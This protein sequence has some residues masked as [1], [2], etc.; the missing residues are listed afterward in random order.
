M[1]LQ[2][3]GYCPLPPV[4]KAKGKDLEKHL[5]LF[6]KGGWLRASGR[7]GWLLFSS[8]RTEKTWL[9]A[10]VWRVYPGVD[11]KYLHMKIKRFDKY[12]LFC[13]SSWSCI[14][15]HLFSP[16]PP[17]P[18]NPHPIYS[19]TISL[20]SSLSCLISLPWSLLLCQVTFKLPELYEGE[21]KVIVSIANSIVFLFI[22]KILF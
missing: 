10:L 22:F 11:G 3:A 8:T 13:V 21:G 20:H 12:F 16:S 1:S 5:L 18:W 4:S 6:S 14:I 17:T 7:Q 2:P 15:Y 9:L 19:T